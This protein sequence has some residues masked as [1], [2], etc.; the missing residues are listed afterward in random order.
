MASTVQRPCAT[1][2]PSCKGEARVAPGMNRGV[3]LTVRYRCSRLPTLLSLRMAAAW[4]AS[5][6]SARRLPGATVKPR[7]T[8]PL[9]ANHQGSTT[10]AIR[11]HEH[12]TRPRCCIV[13]SQHHRFRRHWP[14]RTGKAAEA[15]VAC[16]SLCQRRRLRPGLHLGQSLQRHHACLRLRRRC[17]QRT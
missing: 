2:R 10:L 16:R 17:R 13:K 7:W 6:R 8:S 5:S 14:S 1:T 11:P 4:L 12:Q 3:L 15:K 9:P